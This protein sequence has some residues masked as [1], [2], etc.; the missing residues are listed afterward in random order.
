MITSPIG[1]AVVGFGYWGPNV[2]RNIAERRE[3]RLLGLCE[4]DAMRAD[5]FSRRY[6]GASVA[7]FDAL[8]VDPYV[9]ALTIATPPSTHYELARRALLAGKHVMV[10]LSLIHI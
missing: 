6:P 9:E 8:L 1:I 5:E 3:F 2:V 7:S 10:E 4:Q